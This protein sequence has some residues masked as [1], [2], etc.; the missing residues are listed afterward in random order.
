MKIY[1]TGHLVFIRSKQR[2][3][4]VYIYYNF[5]VFIYLAC[6][7][8]SCS[9]C[10]PTVTV[11][12]IL[13]CCN[14]VTGEQHRRW[15]NQPHR[16]AMYVQRERFFPPYCIVYYEPNQLRLYGDF[17]THIRDLFAE[18]CPN[19]TFFLSSSSSSTTAVSLAVALVVGVM[20]SHTLQHA[21]QCYFSRSLAISFFFFFKTYCTYD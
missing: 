10:F 6:Y 5:T 1:F 18:M 14:G 12:V 17:T 20:Y 15:Y 16:Y 3:L 13:R 8:C 21:L 2:S 11:I 7:G 19:E 4:F 9:H